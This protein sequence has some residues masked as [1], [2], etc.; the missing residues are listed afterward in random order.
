[1]A[2]SVQYPVNKPSTDHL[3]AQAKRSFREIDRHHWPKSFVFSDAA[4][5][6]R[7]DIDGLT[8]DSKALNVR[9]IELVGV[10]I[11]LVWVVV[12]VISN[13]PLGLGVR[14][15]AGPTSCVAR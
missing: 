5:S 9:G 8:T 10:V 2:Y 4:Q 7:L 3:K 15:P 1:M 14:R 13:P 12:F 11:G 6:L